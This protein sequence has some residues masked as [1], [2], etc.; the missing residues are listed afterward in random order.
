M[1]LTRILNQLVTCGRNSRR[2]NRTRYKEYV[3][4]R[5]KPVL[6]FQLC[7]R[8]CKPVDRKNMSDDCTP[9]RNEDINTDDKGKPVVTAV[10]LAFAPLI[11]AFAM[12]LAAI[13]ST[14]RGMNNRVN[15]VSFT[16]RVRMPSINSSRKI[17][18]PSERFE[19]MTRRREYRNDH[20]SVSSSY[21]LILRDKRPI[22]YCMSR[23]LSVTIAISARR[24]REVP[25]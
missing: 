10:P 5:M 19:R 13:A 12:A 24:R 11:A 2:R 17:Q 3:V 4:D 18:Q 7:E 20:C 15:G 25:S 6:R 23:N 16:L 9:W 14:F 21:S 22:S 1:R 8:I